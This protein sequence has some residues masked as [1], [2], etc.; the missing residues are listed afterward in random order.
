MPGFTVTGR[1]NQNSPTLRF[2]PDNGAATF[3][4]GT[5][6][7]D[8]LDVPNS[9]YNSG[10]VAVQV[11]SITVG[12]QDVG[13]A[14]GL[15]HKATHPSPVYTTSEVIAVS[16][17]PPNYNA[18]NDGQYINSGK[19]INAS[20][21]TF[22][23][24]GAPTYQ[25]LVAVNYGLPGPSATL[26]ADGTIT[27]TAIDMNISSLAFGDIASDVTVTVSGALAATI[28]STADATHR[29]LHPYAGFTANS[30]GTAYT[31]D[32]VS[33]PLTSNP[34][35]AAIGFS[36]GP[37]QG[38]KAV[39]GCPVQSK[40]TQGTNQGYIASLQLTSV[41]SV[42][43]PGAGGLP[44]RWPRLRIQNPADA[45]GQPLCNVDLPLCPVAQN[46]KI[47]HDTYTY[48][49]AINSPVSG[50]VMVD[51]NATQIGLVDINAGANS[52]VYNLA[53]AWIEQSP[54]DTGTVAVVLK[55]AIAVT[56]IAMAT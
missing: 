22:I 3:L 8:W 12:D 4:T 7:Y 46:T 5:N 34:F 27:F 11:N 41:T 40:V 48:L 36:G 38:A 56:T 21:G 14:G 42:Y 49:Y 28:G 35:L 39:I 50:G 30:I 15:Y 29:A 52:P 54:D 51:A 31:L 47:F 9:R 1:L 2:V 18:L 16:M 45:G 10:V 43:I 24:D 17:N 25:N 33:G 55:Y 53:N 37:Y 20:A 23:A 44:R 32:L 13:P 6:L 19:A 26:N